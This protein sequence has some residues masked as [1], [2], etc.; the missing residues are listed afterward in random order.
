MALARLKAC[1]MWPPL[2]V[3][4]TTAA[5]TVSSAG[6]RGR[7]LGR[8]GKEQAASHRGEVDLFVRGHGVLDVELF[9]GQRERPVAQRGPVLRA[10]RE[11]ILQGVGQCRGVLGGHDESGVD[12]E[13]G[14]PTD[15]GRNHGPAGSD[16]LQP[17]HRH[18]FAVRA[19]QHERTGVSQQSLDVVGRPEDLDEGGNP[20]SSKGIDEFGVGQLDPGTGAQQAGTAHPARAG[21]R[22]R[23]R[24]CHGPSSGASETAR[25]APDPGRREPGQ[26]RCPRRWGW[27]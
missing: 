2:G 14:A 18:R 27:W 21:S 23:G 17:C 16:G 5:V 6:A 12:D 26:P 15:I 13:R 11:Q 22:R 19:G 4:Q 1:S 20:S 24:G 25:A 8:A 7:S 10:T 9:A 3:R